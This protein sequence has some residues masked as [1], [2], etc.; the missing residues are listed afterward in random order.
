MKRFFQ[1]FFQKHKLQIVWFSFLRIVSFLQLLFWPYAF[2][3]V[4]NIMTKDPTNWRQALVW[5]GLIIF[6]ETVEDF[7]ALRS[8]LGLERIAARLKISLAAFFIEKTE[9]REGIKTGEAVQ[10]IK[11][12]SEAI[13]SLLMFYKNNLL[14]LPVNLIFIPIIF[15]GVGKDYLA[16]L[17]LFM[18]FYLAIEYFCSRAYAR[19]LQTYFKAAETFWG[20]TYRK[21]PD[22]W[23]KREGGYNFSQEIKKQGDELWESITVSN[24][25]NNWRWIFVQVLSTISLGAVIIF[26]IYKIINGQALVGDLILVSGYFKET[27]KSLNIITSAISQIIQGRISL[28]RLVQAVKIKN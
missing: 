12:A 10:V 5:T 13:E 26:V 7:I 3:R 15:I 14:Q 2:A 22:I 1:N 16:I 4:I 18:V 27:Q 28:Q 17:M 23:R 8:Q 24:A 21:A 9:I 19:Q 11:K 20:T 25:T 6:N